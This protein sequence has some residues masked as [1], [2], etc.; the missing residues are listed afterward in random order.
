MLAPHEQRVVDERNELLLKSKKL[1]SFFDNDIFKKM[2]NIDKEL[3]E[4]QYFIMVEY[5]EILHKRIKRFNN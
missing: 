3:L 5:L 2:E 1:E 4:Q